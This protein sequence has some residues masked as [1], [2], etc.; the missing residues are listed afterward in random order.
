MLA[1]CETNVV[2]FVK[3]LKYSVDLV[4]RTSQYALFKCASRREA[5]IT[6]DVLAEKTKPDG[7]FG[8]IACFNSCTNAFSKLFRIFEGEV[9]LQPR[10]ERSF[11]D[12][13]PVRWT[14]AEEWN[15]KM[16][17]GF[18]LSQLSEEQINIFGDGD[19]NGSTNNRL[20]NGT[21]GF[22]CGGDVPKR[23]GITFNCL[24]AYHRL[25]GTDWKTKFDVRQP[26][27]T[28]SGPSRNVQITHRIVATSGVA[29]F[30][31]SDPNA[32]G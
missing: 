31:C 10:Y 4:A 23:L 30:E 19:R 20:R 26:N 21:G 29:L 1:Y 3:V 6:G 25:D 11:P 9:K 2:V 24:M 28:G 27:R 7:V 8:R 16:G 17:L 18:H 22:R 5:S 32:A 15:S 13:E 14:F 12:F